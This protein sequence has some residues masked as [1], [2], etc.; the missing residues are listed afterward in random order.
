MLLVKSV[1]EAEL[2]K[3]RDAETGKHELTSCPAHQ[4]I[5]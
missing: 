4:I 1:S 3:K 2:E 5:L